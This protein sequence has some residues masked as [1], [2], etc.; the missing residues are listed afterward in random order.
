M[1]KEWTKVESDIWN[2]EMGE[3]ITGIYLG[4]QSE[5]GVNK[6][7]LYKIELEDKKFVSIWGSQLLNDALLLVKVGD[8]VKIKFNGKVKPEKGNEYK[9]YEVFTPKI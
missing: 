2:P 8:Q 3:E 6:S 4:V 5:V 7:N 1:E 9:S